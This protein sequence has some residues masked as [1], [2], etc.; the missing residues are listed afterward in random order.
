MDIFLAIKNDDIK[1][2]KSILRGKKQNLSKRKRNETPLHVATERGNIEIVKLLIE[3]DAD[4]NAQD[5]NGW[6]PL[7]IACYNAYEHIVGALIEHGANARI[8]CIL[9]NTPLHAASRNSNI[10][11]VQSLLHCGVDISSCNVDGWTSLHRAVASRKIE[12]VKLLLDNG[13][14]TEMITNSGKTA[15]E[16]ALTMR[17]YDIAG[18]IK[19]YKQQ[20]IESNNGETSQNV[21]NGLTEYIKAKK[22]QMTMLYNKPISSGKVQNVREKFKNFTMVAKREPNTADWTGRKLF[23]F[24][25]HKE[26]PVEDEE[27]E[28]PICFDIPLPPVQIFQCNNG[29]IYCGKCKDMPNMEK[30]P[31]CGIS[32]VGLENRNRYAEE[33]IAK[34]YKDK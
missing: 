5:S 9:G 31:Q 2:V 33:T 12:I 21:S 20:Y 4:V 8:E 22:L 7:Y 6:S 13:I 15:Y 23:S 29:H 28:C 11:I 30:C 25:K 32:I 19:T 14:D 16:L 1:K 24:N 34:L 10:N 26:L 17:Y 18:I 3:H 27:N